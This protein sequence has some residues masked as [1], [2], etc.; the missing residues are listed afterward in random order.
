MNTYMTITCHCSSINITTLFY[1]FLYIKWCEHFVHSWQVSGWKNLPLSIVQGDSIG[2][3]KIR[4]NF[5]AIS[6]T[7]AHYHQLLDYLF[8]Y[9]I[10]FHNTFPSYHP[11]SSLNQMHPTALLH[12]LTIPHNY[13]GQG[14]QQNT[15][16][17]S[18]LCSL[19]LTM[20]NTQNRS[21]N[22]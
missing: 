18:V 19:H 11:Y 6:M 21:R 16:Q 5:N 10:Q 13:G 7:L 8:T 14:R 17:R 22:F 4:V 20:S 12:F 3:C 9:F 15:S 1:S 2:K